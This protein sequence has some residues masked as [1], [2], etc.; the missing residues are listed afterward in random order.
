MERCDATLAVETGG[1]GGELADTVPITERPLPGLEQDG[2]RGCLWSG[3]R[4]RGGSW[5]SPLS[6]P[7][8]HCLPSTRNQWLISYLRSGRNGAQRTSDCSASCVRSS[9]D[10]DQGPPPPPL[11]SVLRWKRQSSGSHRACVGKCV[12]PR[13]LC[14]DLTLL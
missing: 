11:V 7:S 6:P 3:L 13:F 12:C 2:G 10:S 5:E 8:A 1:A 14:V 9:I 4:Q